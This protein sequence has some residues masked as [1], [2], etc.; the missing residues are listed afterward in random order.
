MGRFSAG[1]SSAL[2]PKKD[3]LSQAEISPPRLVPKGFMGGGPWRGLAH[4]LIR[5][6]QEGRLTLRL[7]RRPLKRPWLGAIPC[8]LI[9]QLV[10]PG[11]LDLA[12]LDCTWAELRA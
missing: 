11:G 1:S 2:N 6:N 12:E 4:S 9:A 7:G 5:I 8:P 3:V 10:A